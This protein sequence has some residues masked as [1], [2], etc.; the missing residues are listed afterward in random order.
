[1][2][3]SIVKT[4]QTT[5]EHQPT[6][7]VIKSKTSQIRSYFAMESLEINCMFFSYPLTHK[8]FLFFKSNFNQITETP[9]LEEA[10]L[11]SDPTSKLLSCVLV[12]MIAKTTSDSTHPY[13]Y[14]R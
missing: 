10:L 13:R 11:A 3:R 1:M 2:M 7:G 12:V 8:E 9:V 4:N 14:Q 5:L 6:K